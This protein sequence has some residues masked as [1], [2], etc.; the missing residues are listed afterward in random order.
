[1]GMSDDYKIA[2]S[3]A[4]DYFSAVGVP[5]STMVRIGSLIFGARQGR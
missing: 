1:M 2:L 5:T 3:V 4:S